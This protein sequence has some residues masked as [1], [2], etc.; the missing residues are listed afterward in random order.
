MLLEGKRI[1]LGVTGSISAYKSAELLRLFQKQGAEVRVILTKSAKDFIGELTFKA[2]TEEE[3][4]TDWKDGKTGLE[5]IYWA[6]WG[7]VLVIAPASA[8]TI[9]K[10]RVGIADNFLTSLALA[11]DK[12]IVIAPAMN[13]KM[14]L[15]KATQENLKILKSRGYIFVEPSSGELACHEVGIGKLAD[16]EDILQ[17]TMYAVYSKPFKDKK[18]VITAGGTREYFDPIRYISNNS[19]GYMGYTLAK[20]AH[21]LGGKVTLVSAPTCLKKPYGVKTID[22]VSAKDMYDAVMEESEN[23]DIIIMNAAVADFK[24]KEFSK[25]KL[26]KNKEKPIVELEKNPDILKSLGERKR[27]NQIL[28]GF[29]AESDNI[30]ENAKDKLERKNLDMIVA[31]PVDVFSKNSHKGFILFKDGKKIDIPL[32]TKEKSAL[33]ILQKLAE[34]FINK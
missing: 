32:T 1:L 31:N 11:F 8:N 27:E 29:A 24:P 22:V 4:L 34:E 15:N 12:N 10:L 21:A 7:D 3:V 5:H 26:K 14:Y 23:A 9:A 18:I 16:I 19:S 13:T 17:M 2:L 20:L 33:F 28:V 6:R 25:S 30:F